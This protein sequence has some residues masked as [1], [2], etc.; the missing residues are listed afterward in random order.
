[1]KTTF[2]MKMFF[3]LCL[4]LVFKAAEEF[5]GLTENDTTKLLLILIYFGVLENNK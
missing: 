5:I 3:V 1:M 4:I 2:W